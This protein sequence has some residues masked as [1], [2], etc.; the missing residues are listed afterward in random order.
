MLVIAGNTVMVHLLMQYDVTGLSKAPFIPVSTA[1]LALQIGGLPA[2]IMPGISAFVGGDIVAGIMACGEKMKKDKITYALLIDLGTN[3]EMALIGP[4][5]IFCTATAAGPAFEGGATANVPG[6]DM[7]K[8]VAELL[9]DGV[10][11]ETG[12]LKEPYF[13]QGIVRDGVM[14]HQEDI[15]S[16]QMA[17]AAVFAGIRI[18]IREYGI[19]E[20]EVDRI[21]LAGGFGYKLST[22]AA[23]RIGL[24]PAAMRERTEA[25]GNT[26]LAGAYLYGNKK[27]RAD[28]SP[29]GKR[30]PGHQPG[31]SP[32]ADIIRRATAINL[33]RID[34]FNEIYLHSMN[35]QE[36]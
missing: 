24:I 18:L 4:E 27:Q 23:C 22:A 5:R 15:R 13:E 20:M 8:I 25:V 36:Y 3:G 6:S 14:L 32:A 31:Q 34:D 26:A 7:I 17:K 2:V 9:E 30:Q 10:I 28:V 16:L 19:T 11:D 33:A 21:Y 12:L 35:L 29:D 1:E